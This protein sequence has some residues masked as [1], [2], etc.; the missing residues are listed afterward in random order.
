MGHFM[1][2]GAGALPV[3]G[4]TS[5]VASGRFGFEGLPTCYKIAILFDFEKYRIPDVR[6]SS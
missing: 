1:R 2:I 4:G 5:P 6:N 3:M